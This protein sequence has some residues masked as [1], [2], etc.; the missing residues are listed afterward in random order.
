[1]N[2]RSEFLA[3]GVVWVAVAL[4]AGCDDGTSTPDG[5]E[6]PP[7]DAGAA[8]SGSDAGGDPDAGPQDPVFALIAQQRAGDNPL[9]YVVLADAIDREATLTLDDGIE[10]PG[11]SIGAGITRGGA[12]FVGGSEGPTLT[13]YDL[14][15]DSLVE[16]D[17]ISFEGAGVASIGEYQGQFYFVSETKAYYLDPRTAQAVVWN[18]TAME[19]RGTIDLGGLARSDVTANYPIAP[20]VVGDDLIVPVGWRD[21]LTVVDGVAVAVIDTTTDTAVVVSDTRCGYA[22]TAAVG[23]DGRVYIA[24]DAFGASVHR[25]APAMAPAPCMLRFDPTTATF[26][27]A[28][29]VELSTL[30]GGATAAGLVT[31]PDG[32]TFIRVLD[33]SLTTID[34]TTS[35]VVLRSLPVWTWWRI[36]LGDTPSATQVGGARPS[37]GSTIVLNADDDQPAIADFTGQTSTTLIDFSAGPGGE[38]T[39][40]IPGLVFSAVRLR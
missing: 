9:T 27:A 20:V 19:V 5:G 24:V 3:L 18:P 8:D 28:Y 39:L 12:L 16:R 1:M 40:T 11:R 17:S 4:T 29:E 36:S 7:A 23:A 26:D 32:S 10:L 14:V 35:P 30:V 31:A 33:E 34:D 25:I 2:A 21:G 13:R 38:D 37:I 15:A 6:Q 22:S